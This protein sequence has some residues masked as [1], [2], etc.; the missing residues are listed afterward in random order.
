MESTFL[1][2]LSCALDSLVPFITTCPS[3]LPSPAPFLLIVIDN[4]FYQA[5]VQWG[6]SQVFSS[7]PIFTQREPY[8]HPFCLPLLLFYSQTYSPLAQASSFPLPKC[9]FFVTYPYAPL[10]LTPMT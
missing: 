3:F 4:V 1:P 10:I 7:V 8:V 9:L 6:D 5:S 2:F